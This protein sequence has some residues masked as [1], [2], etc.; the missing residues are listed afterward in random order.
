MLVSVSDTHRRENPGLPSHLQ[1]VVEAADIVTH[2]GDFTSEAVLDAFETIADSFVAVPGNR[3]RPAVERRLP[4]TATTEWAGHRFVLA[5]GHEHD[6]TALSLLARQED[7]D[8]IL[9]GHTHRPVIDTIG[10][11][12][13]VNP[14][15]YAD[16]RRY[17]PAYAAFEDTS[18]ALRVELRDPNGEV[19]E[20]QS[21]APE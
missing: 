17:R 3:D 9:T 21:V 14:G 12:L 19:F 15:S 20:S 2:T 1:S 4:A 10:E 8:V 7:A 16:P 6:E 13:H 11:C 18:G 5:H